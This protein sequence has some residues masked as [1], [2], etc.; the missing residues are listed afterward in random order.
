MEAVSHARKDHNPIAEVVT[1][2]TLTPEIMVRAEE[3]ELARRLPAD[4]AQKL[5][6]TGLFRIAQPRVYGGTECHP[7]DIVRVIEEVSQA[8]G[9]VGWCVM[10]AAVT[11]T[12]AKWKGVSRSWR[13]PSNRTVA[14]G[15]WD[16]ELSVDLWGLAG[17]GWR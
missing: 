4:L 2:R 7:S 12:L 1:A 8:D 6:A 3:I 14:V 16:T 17:H 10:I 13:L 15:Q 9:S 5:A 11:A